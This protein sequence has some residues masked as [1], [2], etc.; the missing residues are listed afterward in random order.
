MLSLCLPSPDVRRPAFSAP[1]KLCGRLAELEFRAGGR[2]GAADFVCFAGEVAEISLDCV[3]SV[4]FDVERAWDPDGSGAAD[5]GA[6]AVCFVA[7]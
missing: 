5:D 1:Y 4:G 7:P 6:G 2:G 3:D